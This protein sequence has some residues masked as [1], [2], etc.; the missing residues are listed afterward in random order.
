MQDVVLQRAEVPEEHRVDAVA[1]QPHG[2]K[3]DNLPEQPA[4]QRAEAIHQY[5]DESEIYKVE[6]EHAGDPEEEV[7]AVLHT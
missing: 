2:V 3:H 6:D 4:S 5:P 7:E 1:K